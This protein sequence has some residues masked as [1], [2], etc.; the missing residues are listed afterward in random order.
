MNFIKKLSAL[1]WCIALATELVP[2][3]EHANHTITV[4]IHGTYPARK[5]LQHVP[6]VRSLT[7]CPQG[8]S[9]A[10]DL[11]N[12]Y[13]FK[14]LAQGCVDYNPGYYS[15]DR[16]YLF[17]WPSEHVTHNARLQAAANLM[18]ELQT[19]VN[20]YYQEFQVIPQIQL[21][22][23]SHGGNVILNTA[24]CEPLM[25]DT[26]K[27]IVNAWIFGTPV[28]EV[29]EHLI[30]SQ[31]FTNVYSIYSKSDWIQRMDP[32]GLRD[33][34]CRKRHFWSD[35]T[36][37]SQ[38]I[39]TQVHLTVNNKSISHSYYRCILKYLPKIQNLVAKELQ[40]IHT[41]MININLEV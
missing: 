21:V 29:N 18:Q 3:Q 22:G 6:G 35:R 33:K 4:Y 12:G 9:K 31:N 2:A 37:N 26:T 25:I 24:L 1:L 41:K 30:N 20:N 17:G 7:Y 5:Y 13:H 40:N 32:Q 11:P 34:K 27:V 19:L 28:Q 23:F 10:Q 16:F 14:K 15:F 38:S 39:C 8:L 36:F